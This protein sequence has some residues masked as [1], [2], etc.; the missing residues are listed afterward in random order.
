MESSN[1]DHSKV[2]RR[3]SVYILVR[4]ERFNIYYSKVGSESSV[5]VYI[6]LWWEQMLQYIERDRRPIYIYINGE[7]MPLYILL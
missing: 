2:G 6:I 7:V 5:L 4:I 3:T 1:I